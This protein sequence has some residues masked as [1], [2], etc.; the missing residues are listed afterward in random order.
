MS[1]RTIPHPLV[2]A[3]GARTK[4]PIAAQLFGID[5]TAIRSELHG[6]R[7]I[8]AEGR[9]PD[10]KRATQVSRIA[11]M[12]AAGFDADSVIRQARVSQVI[13]G[14]YDYPDIGHAIRALRIA[15]S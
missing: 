6:R 8:H 9:S 2:V 10:P 4:L 1:A 12:D 13:R 3:I 14:W 15:A 11:R 7:G 5:L